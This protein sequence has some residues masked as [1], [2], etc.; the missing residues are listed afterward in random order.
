MKKFLTLLFMFGIIALFPAASCAGDVYLITTDDQR[1]I[2]NNISE[3]GFKI[4]NE[5]ELPNRTVFLYDA[6]KTVNAGSSIYGR[7]IIVCRGLY[8]MLDDEDMLAAILSHE[9]AHSM[10]SYNGPFRGAFFIFNSLYGAKKYEYKADKRAV[11]YMV[12]AGYH[13]VASIVIMNK[14]MGQ[15]RY[16]WQSSH[17]LTS[18]RM[19]AIYEYIYKKY[20]E[21]LVNNKYKTNIYYQNFLLTSKENRAKFQ[22]KVEKKSRGKVD[23]L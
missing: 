16:D 8:T 11:D 7:R 9:I 1:D 23:Y 6:S 19:M 10:D 22:Q 14:A 12:K 18:R 17:P 5:N 3:I 15:D 21:Y 4:L 2:Q 13:P 20:P